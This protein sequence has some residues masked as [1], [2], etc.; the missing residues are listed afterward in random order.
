MALALQ[1]AVSVQ[2]RTADG[3]SLAGAIW[4]YLGYFTILTNLPV[5]VTH[6]RVALGRWPG[7]PLGFADPPRWLVYPVTC[8]AYLLARGAFDGWYPYFS[9]DFSIDV[10]AIGHARALGNSAAL[11]VTMLIAGFAVVAAVRTLGQR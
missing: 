1:L 5:A 9:I 7:G 6:M 11:S 2:M 3:Y 4:R 10:A 8:L